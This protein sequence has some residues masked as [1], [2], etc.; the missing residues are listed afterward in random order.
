MQCTTHT[1]TFKGCGFLSKSAYIIEIYLF[2]LMTLEGFIHNYYKSFK[3]SRCSR[4]Q[5]DALKIWGWKLLRRM[6]MCTFCLNILLFHSVLPFRSFRNDLNVSQKTKQ[7]QFTLIIQFQ[8]FSPPPTGIVVHV[9]LNCPQR[10]NMD[11]KTV[12]S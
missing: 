8:K 3:H 4:R 7:V 11:V 6:M 1:M 9:S 10:E 2:T 12:Q 5:H